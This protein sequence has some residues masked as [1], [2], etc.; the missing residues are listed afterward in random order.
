MYKKAFWPLHRVDS[1][2]PPTP[3]NINDYERVYL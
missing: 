1:T 3:R 2:V